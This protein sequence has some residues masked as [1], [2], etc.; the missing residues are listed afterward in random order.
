MPSKEILIRYSC[1]RKRDIVTGLAVT[2]L[3]LIVAAQF[4]LTLIVPVQ[5]QKYNIYQFHVEK[6]KVIKH[7]D[8]FRR[9]IRKCD[10]SGRINRGEV[11]LVRGAMNQLIIYVTEHQDNMDDKQLFKMKRI[12]SDFYRYLARWQEK[13]SRYHIRQ[14][15]I[16]QTK[17][18]NAIVKELVT[19]KKN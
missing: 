11:E 12:F 5:L 16:N 3:L 7:V 8:S 19:E 6:D 10:P 13:P 2:M 14:E 17:L 1:K 4:Y 15:E 9:E 18:V